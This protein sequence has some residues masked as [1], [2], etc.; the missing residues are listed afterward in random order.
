MFGSPDLEAASFDYL[1]SPAA[2]HFLA[3]FSL[4]YG[5]DPLSAAMPA[6]FALT[7]LIG[8]AVVGICRSIFHLP[9][10]AAVTIGCIFLTNSYFT[11][12]ASAYRLATLISV[13]ILLFILWVTVRARSDRAFDGPLIAVLTSA[14]ALLFFTDVLALVAAVTLQAIAIL[15]FAAYGLNVRGIAVSSAVSALIVALAFVDRLQWSFANLDLSDGVAAVALAL[16]VALVA[17]TTHLVRRDDVLNRFAAT[18]ADR[19]LAVAAVGYAAIAIIAGNVAVHAA[20]NPVLARMPG[21]WRG[22]EQ[23][24][25]RP[26]G[27]L[28]L[29]VSYDPRGLACG[30][31]PL[32][33]ARQEGPC[34]RPGRQ[35]PCAALR[36]DFT[37]QP[38]SHAELRVRRSRP[39]RCDGDLRRRLRDVCAARLR[40]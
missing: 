18:P 17:G 8:V 29:K 13:P 20:R 31:D 25:D 24:K 1:R 28:T 37:A 39:R 7:A 36:N 2:S 23:L 3:G 11:D 35:A 5:Q 9:K 19:R 40:A 15:L 22:I 38:D 16:A 10:L 30:R 6:Q 26:F 33:S 12:V 21:R 4:A 27:E 14:Y 32:F 34:H